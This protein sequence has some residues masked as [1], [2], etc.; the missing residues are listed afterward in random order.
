M[1]KLGLIGGMGPESTLLYYR[2][3]A[4]AYHRR[5]PG[6][7]FPALTI[8]T[9]DM[10]EMLGYCKQQDWDGLTG[11]LTRAVQSCEAAG[12]GFLTMASNTPHVVFDVLRARAAV[13]MLSIMEPVCR[14]VTARGLGKVAWLGTAFTMEQPYFRQCFEEH[15]IAVV[16]PRADERAELDRIIA[17]ELEFGVKKPGSKRT[18]DA[19]IA[20]LIGE[21]HAEGVV[22]GCTELPLLY[23]GETLPVPCV[24]TL[25]CHIEGIVDRMLEP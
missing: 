3:I 13:P 2:E 6:C 24:D 23:A 4:A 9:V 8:E 18:V 22:L 16:V 5:A 15:G 7:A 12:A 10:Y 21:A 19:V 17:E 25:R 11:C 20:R 14:A 1:K